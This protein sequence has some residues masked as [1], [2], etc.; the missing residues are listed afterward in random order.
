MSGPAEDVRIYDENIQFWQ[1][2]WNQVKAPHTQMPPLDYIYRIPAGLA[3]RKSSRVLD[4]GCGSGWLSVFLA[5]EGFRVI[6]V[7]IACHAI[8]LAGKWAGSEGL[9]I[10]FL[11][12]DITAL[13][14]PPAYFGSV[15]GNSIF[16]HLTY[17]M[18]EQ[19]VAS[20]N[21]LLEVGGIFLGC[22]DRVGTGP[23]KYYKL[24]D[25]THVYTDEGR[26]GMML[27]CFSNDEIIALFEEWQIEEM[28]EI[29]SG[30]RLLIARK[31]Q[32]VRLPQY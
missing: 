15:V 6:G 20:L 30:S 18:A 25:G 27:R 9:Q 10:E 11:T 29:A 4:L 3:E 19:T 14:F 22:F 1:S 28:S 24:E 2:A 32:S 7:D 31:N 8:E 5:R 26:Q 17:K 12:Q 16:E 13:N 21:N 23:G